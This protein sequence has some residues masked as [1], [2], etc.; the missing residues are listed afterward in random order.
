[1]TPEVRQLPVE[2]PERV[3]VEAPGDGESGDGRSRM[4]GRY[5]HSCRPIMAYPSPTCKHTGSCRKKQS[6]NL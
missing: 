2:G 4:E 3:E 5:K 6:D 1:M